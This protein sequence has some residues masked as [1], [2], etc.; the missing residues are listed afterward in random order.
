MAD[1]ADAKK[2]H[3]ADHRRRLRERYA[4]GGSSGLQ[5]YELLELLLTYAIPRRDVKPLAKDLIA[6]FGSLSGVLDASIPELAEVKGMGETSATLLR[7]V[8]DLGAVYLGERLEQKPQ[9]SA[10]TDVLDYARA[11]LSGRPHEAFMVLFLDTQ[12]RLIAHEILSEGTVDNVVV[13]PRRIVEAALG[14]NA[15]A[16]ILVHNHPSGDCAPSPDDCSLTEELARTT[17]TLD[18]HVLDHLIIGKHDHTSFAEQGW[19]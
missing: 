5:D 18:I 17:S 14:H 4:R 7:L 19:L 16:L 6:A 3:Y 15:A 13:Y 10:A 8:Q 2:P 11:A 1:S 12:N 9:V